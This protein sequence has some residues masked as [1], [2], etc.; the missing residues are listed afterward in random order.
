MDYV[1]ILKEAWD[2]TW[3]NRALWILG[4]F[5]TGGASISTGRSMSN[6]DME[7]WQSGGAQN[8]T[9][10]TG[11]EVQQAFDELGA[12]L[13]VQFG[14][15]ADWVPWLI[16]TGIMLMF[17]A[18]ITCLVFAVLGIAARGG[19]VHQVNEA[20]AGRQ[21]RASAGWRMGFRYFWRVLGISIV[22]ALPGIVL[23]IIGAAAFFVFGGMAMLLDGPAVAGL[24]TMGIVM[25][26]LAIVALPL[27]IIISM[28]YEVSFRH[29]IL[30]ERGVIDS[31]KASWADLWGRRGVASMWL[32]MILVYIVLAVLGGIV[33]VPLGLTIALFVAGSVA[34]AGWGMLWLIVPAAVVMIAV[35]MLLKAVFSTFVSAAWTSFYVR[36]E[37]P[38]P[39]VAA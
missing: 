38:E 32:V 24:V 2:V 27:S 36:I 12:E 9:T 20:L 15:V 34:A 4:L 6:G 21:V 7:A 30:A 16:V 17:V 18:L 26:M 35:M 25:A 31:V 3:R 28:L 13:G 10:L 1:G 8:G 33:L 19:L 14:Q 37:R 11:L 29:A 23:G 39:A 5:V 22:L